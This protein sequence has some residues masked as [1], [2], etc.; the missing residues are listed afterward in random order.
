[1]IDGKVFSVITESSTQKCG[2]CGATPKC[3]N[4]IN[5]VL[6][7]NITENHLNFGLSILH[8]WIRSFETLLHI[9]Y[10]LSVCK[11]QIRNETEKKIVEERKRVI[12]KIFKED[13]GLLV[14]LPKQGF[15]TTNDGNTARRFFQS[16]SIAA[17]ITGIDESLIKRFAVIL[18]T[19]S[20]VFAVDSEAFRS[21]AITTGK[22]FVDLYPWYYMPSSIHKILI[23][24]A[25]IINKA[26]LPIGMFSEEALESRNKDFKS[27][28]RNNTRKMSRKYTM[29][30]LFN[31]LLLS[32]DPLISTISKN[33]S[34][35]SKANEALSEEVL[36]LL[37]N[38]ED[39]FAQGSDIPEQDEEFDS[40]SVA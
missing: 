17:D 1:M 24:G 11:W 33:H 5:K 8:A 25:D 4:D 19:M 39:Y 22:M 7:R 27:Y 29:Q 36:K 21:Y 31:I 18:Q 38:P 26:V 37:S 32:S 3:M 35:I 14:D 20:Y 6:E 23:H 9:S 10:R 16:P 13:M 30:D 28:R 34:T 2:I 40:S 15:G 12:I